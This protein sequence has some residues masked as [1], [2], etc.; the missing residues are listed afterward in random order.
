MNN[1]IVIKIDYRPCYVNGKKALFHKWCENAQPLEPSPS[2]LGHKGGQ[3]WHT[4]GL[5]EVED[6][7][8]KFVDPYCIKFCDNLI[9]HYYFKEE[10]KNEIKG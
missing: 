8:V 2:I 4:L 10:F 3:L 6:G 5:V 9:S 1:E 7:S